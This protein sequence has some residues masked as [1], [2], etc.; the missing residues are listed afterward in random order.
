[1]DRIPGI[2]NGGS[3]APRVPEDLPWPCTLYACSRLTEHHPNCDGNCD[4]YE[5]TELQVK[6]QNIAFAYAR[7]D[8]SFHGVPEGLPF[9]GIDVG[10]V[11]L[12][13][14]IMC[15]EEWL[16]EDKG[17]DRE[18]Y[19]EI[20]RKTKIEFLQNILDANLDRIKRERTANALGIIEK[21]P[22]FGPDG[23]QIG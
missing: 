19:D 3:A 6:L 10:L 22:I 12:L 23:Q 21:K 13:C 2:R 4:N 17:I 7:N 11:D 20:F 14:R 16:F 15:L 5:P 8:M 18:E 1:M 9:P